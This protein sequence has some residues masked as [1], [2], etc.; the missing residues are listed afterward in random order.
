RRRG[1]RRAR[2][3]AQVDEHG[4]IPDAAGSLVRDGYTFTGFGRADAAGAGHYSFTTVA[5]GPVPGRTPFVAMT[6][7]ARGLLNR[8][9]TRVYL[10]VEGG[11]T[12][13]DAFLDTLPE[14]RRSTLVARPD[15]HGFVFDIHLQGE[16]ETVFLDHAGS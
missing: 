1:C 15:D 8:L 3:P 9:F 13:T 10:P 4:D 16:H 6:V 2:R 5:P 14:E 11:A 7:L 12:V